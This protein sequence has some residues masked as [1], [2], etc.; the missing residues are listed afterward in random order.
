MLRSVA[1]VTV[2]SVLP[3]MALMGSVAVIVTVPGSSPVAR[4]LVPDT[5]LIVAKFVSEEDQVTSEL[6]S[7]TLPS[8]NVP[9]AVNCAEVPGAIDGLGGVTAMETSVA[10]LTVMTTEPLIAVPGSVA[11]MVEVPL[12]RVVTKPSLPG[13]LLTV[14]TP[15]AEEDHV[16]WVDRS[17]VAPS[18]NVPVAVSC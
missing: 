11:V 17:C 18:L 6:K 9:S 12:D 10:A 7:W 8:V 13:A 14:A 2:R 4:P 15:L 5:L 16:T 3:G 1:E